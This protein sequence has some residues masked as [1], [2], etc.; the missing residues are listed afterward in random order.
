M[1][2]DSLPH[3][4]TAKLRSRTSDALGGSK[5][6]FTTV[7]ADRSCWRQ[8]ASTNERRQAQ[9]RGI[10]I[11]DK[12]FF[13]TDPELDERHVLVIDGETLSVRNYAHPDAS[14]GLG[15]VFRVFAKLEDYDA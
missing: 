13:V 14:A 7:F 4:A 10:D 3:T 12:V 11:S 9:R 15:K 6:T 5:D 1:L 2:L 8:P